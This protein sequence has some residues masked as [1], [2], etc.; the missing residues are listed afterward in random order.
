MPVILSEIIRTPTTES[1]PTHSSNCSLI[2]SFSRSQE[3]FPTK[4]VVDSSDSSWIFVF[5]AGCSASCSGFA[6]FFETTRVSSS[7]SSS[8]D[9]ASDSSS[10]LDCSSDEDSS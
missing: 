9:D 4:M 6:R 5:L 2:A 3:Q 1:A 7:C 8:S 10:S